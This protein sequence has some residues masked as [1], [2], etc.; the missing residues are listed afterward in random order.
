[1]KAVLLFVTLFSFQAFAGEFICLATST[2]G[3]R[4]NGAMQI[5]AQVDSEMVVEELTKTYM[6]L[7]GKADSEPMRIVSIIMN[8]RILEVTVAE[9]G[10]PG[11]QHIIKTRAVTA[12]IYEGIQVDSYNG[13][14]YT[15]PV[16]CTAVIDEPER[17]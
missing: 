2:Y 17:E 15:Y 8:K 10:D 9:P 11:I 3:A 16:A 7:F 4:V 6:S 1:M 12:G 5:R 13:H 14:R